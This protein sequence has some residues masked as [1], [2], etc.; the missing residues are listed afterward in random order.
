MPPKTYDP[1]VVNYTDCTAYTDQWNVWRCVQYEVVTK[2]YCRASCNNSCRVFNPYPPKCSFMESCIT[3]EFQ[4]PRPDTCGMMNDQL[5]SDECT[6]KTCDSDFGNLGYI[7]VAVGTPCNYNAANG[8]SGYCN[9]YTTCSPKE[10]FSQTLPIVSRL[11]DRPS[12]RLTAQNVIEVAVTKPERVTSV[13]VFIQNVATNSYESFVM[14]KEA[15]SSSDTTAVYSYTTATPIRRNATVV[16]N[17]TFP[18]QNSTL[19]FRFLDWNSKSNV[20]PSFTAPTYAVGGAFGITIDPIDWVSSAVLYSGYGPSASATNLNCDFGFASKCSA[21][22]VAGP[23]ANDAY[24]ALSLTSGVIVKRSLP[25]I[26][27]S[28]IGVKCNTSI[29]TVRSTNKCKAGLYINFIGNNW[30]QVG[31]LKGTPL[32]W[33][34]NFTVGPTN[35][36]LTKVTWGDVWQGNSWVGDIPG[37]LTLILSSGEREYFLVPKYSEARINDALLC[38]SGVA[39]PAPDEVGASG[40]CVGLNRCQAG[41]LP[42]VVTTTKTTTTSTTKPMTTTVP[43]STPTSTQPPSTSKS[44]TSTTASTTVTYTTQTSTSTNTTTKTTLP[45]TT[46]TTTNIPTTTITQTASTTSQAQS[47]STLIPSTNA[48]TRT[49]T[50]STTTA[51]ASTTT[52]RPTT[53]SSTSQSTSSLTQPTTATTTATTTS[54]IPTTTPSNTPSSSTTATTAIPTSTSTVQTATTPTSVTSGASTSSTFVTTT[55]VPPTTTPTQVSIS[56]AIVLQVPS[57]TT[58][59]SFV[60]AFRAA[61]NLP[62]SANSVIVVLRV[63][64]TADKSKVSKQGNMTYFVI[65]FAGDDTTDAVLDFLSGGSGSVFSSMGVGYGAAADTDLVAKE[66]DNS[67][68]SFTSIGIIVGIVAG[69]VLIIIAV[70]V[71]VVIVRMK[72]TVPKI[73]FETTPPYGTPHDAP[74][75]DHH[76]PNLVMPGAFVDYA[77][78]EK[79]MLET[80]MVG[81]IPLKD[82]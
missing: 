60:A 26:S 65:G 12:G 82:I 58:F 23:L 21:S 52:Q 1:Q 33:I 28:F 80:T 9:G 29:H 71:A 18:G 36:Q 77:A 55:S 45:S 64:T 78:G 35:K 14:T 72:R 59:E 16:I 67:P 17:T 43:T 10:V 75:E 51:A 61:Y 32:A 73:W 24:V 76:Q 54:V 2:G 74:N 13:K 25:C 30:L 22:S 34:S 69:V 57:S 68:P 27:E 46:P 20:V 8:A 4:P 47:T 6:L 53:Q 62:E 40:A 44:T 41:A 63:A 42:F 15:G 70:A 50:T 66:A 11:T 31:L 48:T 49:S 7:P 5:L 56:R 81:S 3:K 39:V 19:T 37:N 38:L 79:V